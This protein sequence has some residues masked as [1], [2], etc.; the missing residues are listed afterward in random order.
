MKPSMIFL[1]NMKTIYKLLSILS[2]LALFSCQNLNKMPVFDNTDAFAAFDMTSISVSERAGRIKLPVTIASIEP[3]NTTVS[4]KVSEKGGTAK[5]GVNYNLV[6]ESAVIKYDGVARTNY[7][8]IDVINIPGY[9][10]DVDLRLELV[11]AVGL[12]LGANKF[13]KISI[14]DADHPLA[15]LLGEYSAK[16]KTKDNGEVTWN[17][18]I[19]K[20]YT[21][22]EKTQ[23]SLTAVKVYNIS[24]WLAAKRTYPNFDNGY[25]A[26]VVFDKD[27]KIVG[28]KM[29]IGQKLPFKFTYKGTEYDILLGTFEDQADDKVEINTTSGSIDLTWN[30][31]AVKVETNV[32]VGIS[33]GWLDCIYSEAS[34]TK[35]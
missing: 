26:N 14:K 5:P 23:T 1:N 29:D 11:N 22:K 2:V 4:Y 24:P 9:T 30:G 6:D 17:I 3:V 12:N 16:G 8:E 21:D 35:K 25:I 32:F 28:L 27:K 33:L 34:W 15:E 31:N 19:E 7:I 18:V 10:G 20:L 13:C